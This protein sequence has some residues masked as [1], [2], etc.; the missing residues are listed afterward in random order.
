MG[1]ASLPGDAEAGRGRGQAGGQGAE[2]GGR[3]QKE[4]EPLG[5]DPAPFS[6]TPPTFPVGPAPR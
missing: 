5:F 3:R 1:G 2:L 6:L 4:A